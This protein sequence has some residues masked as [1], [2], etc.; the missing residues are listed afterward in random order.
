MQDNLPYEPTNLLDTTT[1]PSAI[2]SLLS[3]TPAPQKKSPQT[4]FLRQSTSYLLPLSIFLL[5]LLV[6]LLYNLTIARNYTPIFDAAL[7]DI[8]ARHLLNRH[9]YCLVG[10]RETVS[11]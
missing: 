10:N 5:A 3:E 9:C 6:R 11:R 8:L 7:Y 2:S 4:T 1:L